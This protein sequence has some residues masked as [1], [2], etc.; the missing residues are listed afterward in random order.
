MK[1]LIV[2]LGIAA[3]LTKA[4]TVTYSLQYFTGTEI[5]RFTAPTYLNNMNEYD[6]GTVIPYQALTVCNGCGTP[7]Q[8]PF[9][10]FDGLIIR[11]FAQQP[12]TWIMRNYFQ[13][14]QRTDIFWSGDFYLLRD[15]GMPGIFNSVTTG[16]F[17]TRLVVTEGNDPASTT[18]EPSSFLL[19]AT[20]LP[21][22]YFV[23]KLNRG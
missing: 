14:D 23:R 10:Q 19:G 12:S 16:N 3:G 21:M 2:L 7:G 11:G 13:S 17:R 5:A 20:A 1:K 9:V 22:L 8:Y 4:T 15:Q 6:F 18:P